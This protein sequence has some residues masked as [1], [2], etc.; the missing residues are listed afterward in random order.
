MLRL[1]F[2]EINEPDAV[3]LNM[4]P[5]AC[6]KK[7]SGDC[8]SRH[9]PFPFQVFTHGTQPMTTAFINQ[10]FAR[11][12]ARKQLTPAARASDE[13]FIRRV[14]LDLAGRIATPAEVLAFVK[15][16]GADKR[17]RLI[18]RLLASADYVEHWASLWVSWL[19]P[20][21][22]RADPVRFAPLPPLYRQQLHDWLTKEQRLAR[23]NHAQL[24]QQLLTAT[25]KTDEN[26][27]VHFL[28][29]NLGAALVRPAQEGAF[30]MVPATLRTLRVFLGLDLY[31][32][33][34][35]AQ[36]KR[37]PDWQE[38]HFWALNVF[39]R[40][41][42]RDGLALRD[43][44]AMNRKGVLFYEL[45]HGVFLPVEAAYFDRRRTPDDP[46]L[47]ALAGG[48][49]SA[50][51]RQQQSQRPRRQLLADFISTDPQFARASVNRVWGQLFGRGLHEKP[52]VDDFGSHNE[53]LHPDLLTRLAQD[54]A[55]ANF[56]PQ[57]L[58]RWIANS[59]VYQR[60]SAANASND[61][62]TLEAYFSR[63]PVRPLGPEQ[64][65]ASLLRLIQPKT[66]AFA[67]SCSQW[68]A[69]R[70]EGNEW[71]DV[72]A[73]D[74][75]PHL[76]RFL[77]RKETATALLADDCAALT[78]D[79]TPEALYL[80]VLNR[81]PTADETKAIAAQLAPGKDRRDQARD[82]L[83]ALVNSSEFVLQH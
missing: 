26:G 48:L 4:A 3:R 24:V 62:A 15:D 9:W 47:L 17:Q 53:L 45:P 71:E 43:N 2:A 37:H 79:T 19:L 41:V 35:P 30:D 55:A 66:S 61:A 8:R 64:L 42:E 57:A 78:N 11:A 46:R 52:A 75:L 27:A 29:A 68:F 60:D 67:E 40:Q 82:L 83:W 76:L 23:L 6:G 80:A 7:P 25:G 65:T 58:L 49:G 51:L 32:L 10:Y 14:S 73:A 54:F 13:T 63:M 81:R 44:A 22:S 5:S 50:A 36:P 56:D 18:D 39:F 31:G 16:A 33:H 1:G 20:R 28:L 21:T 12:W 38:K 69:Q 34:L 72:P 59:D 70:F 74:R 77:N